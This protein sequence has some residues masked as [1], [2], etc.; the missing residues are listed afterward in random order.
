MPLT[1]FPNGISA[2][3]VPMMGSLP[4]TFGKVLF[5]DYAHGSDGNGGLSSEEALKTLTQAY[6]LATTDHDDLILVRGGS[7]VVDAP[8]LW[9]KNR[10]HVIGVDGTFG[11]INQQG[12]KIWAATA[13]A[14]SY[15]LK[16]TGTRNSFTNL[17][18]IQA[19][20]VATALQVVVDAGEGT[21]W[22]N[23]SMIFEV[24]DNL[25][26]TTSTEL[27]CGG[28]SSNFIRCSFGTDVLLT[29]AARAVVTLD[30]VSGSASGDAAKSNR[31]VD[32][33][34]LIMSSSASALLL[35]V[36]DTGAAKFLNIFER[37]K[38]L[39]AINQTSVAITLDDAVASATGLV[40]GNI[41]I[42]S[43]ATNCT[44]VGDTIT[45]NVKVIGN[46]PSTTSGI[47]ATP[48]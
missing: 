37:P 29:S 10:I 6:S 2:F 35:K 48:A 42:I 28:D 25:D 41:L 43:P 7:T 33:E 9:S 21:L 15:V 22:E 34:F 4:M 13:G 44:K 8:I 32:C 20:T 40:E 30:N 16:V 11:R 17:K 26:L 5:V 19:S 3:G 46:A 1:N 38:F 27:L 47:G 36:A 31:F 39:A 12:A 23:C 24:A 18:I 45:D 14:T